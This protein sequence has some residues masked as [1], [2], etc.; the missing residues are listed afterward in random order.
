MDLAKAMAPDMPTK[1]V[2]IRPGEKIDEIMC[3]T[4]DSHLTLEFDDHYVIKPAI[5]F[6]HADIDY[7]INNIGEKGT[8]VASG[9]AYDSGTNYEFL[10]VEELKELNRQSGI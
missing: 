5:T 4:D 10:S 9:A 3:P 8:P 7:T 1:I 2:G 6:H